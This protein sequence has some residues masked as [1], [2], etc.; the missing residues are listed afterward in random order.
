MLDVLQ[1]IVRWIGDWQTVVSCVFVGGEV[2]MVIFWKLRPLVFGYE[3]GPGE[4][5]GSQL[6]AE[7]EH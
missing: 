1:E 3:G 6:G 7:L 4:A 5:E 2:C